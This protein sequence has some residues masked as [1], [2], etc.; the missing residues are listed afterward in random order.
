MGKRKIYVY[1]PLLTTV[2]WRGIVLT[3]YAQDSKIEI[4]P[5]E[6]RINVATGVDGDHTYNINA[7][8]SGTVKVVLMA[9][10]PHSAMLT[11]DAQSSTRGQL[12][13]RDANADGGFIV[14]EDDCILL[15]APTK[16]RA[17]NAE[18]EEFT[19]FVPVLD[20]KAA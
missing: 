9:G 12:V 3:G 2:V 18:A 8:K 15:G 16:K 20:Y 6:K 11:E 13:I 5:K 14:A 7:N 1:D 17:K 19:F 10:S 4:A